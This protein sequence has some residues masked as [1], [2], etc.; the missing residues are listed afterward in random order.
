MIN[1]DSPH[2]RPYSTNSGTWEQTPTAS[3]SPQQTLEDV[4]FL[5]LGSTNSSSFSE[6]ERVAKENIQPKPIT[7]HKISI[8]NSTSSLYIG[9]NVYFLSVA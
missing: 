3:Y 2:T 9:I 1:S 7:E 8:I 5:L 4:E 6:E